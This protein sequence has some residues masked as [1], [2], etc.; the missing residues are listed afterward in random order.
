MQYDVNP[1]GIQQH[2]VS[3]AGIEADVRSCSTAAETMLDGSAFG[4]INQFLAS[5]VGLF[6]GAVNSGISDAAADLGETVSILR[7]QVTNY[8]DDDASAAGNVAGAGR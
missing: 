2:A 7:T 8:Q 6:A 3:L 5:T 1:T 4:V